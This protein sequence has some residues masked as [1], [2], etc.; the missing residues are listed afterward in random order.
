MATAE[1]SPARSQGIAREPL[2]H[3]SRRFD[4][5]I[6]DAGWKSPVAASL[7]ENLNTCLR[8]QTSS[9]I[10]IL[11]QEQCFE[12]F[13]NF[14][15]SIGNEPSIIIIDRDAYA[16]RRQQGFGFKLN[17]GLVRDEAT[18]NNLMKWVMAVLAEQTP[19]SDITEPIRT[20]IHKEGMRGAIDIL[21]D[22]AR[23]PMGEAL[24]H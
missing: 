3:G 8:Y 21:A 15:A 24:T 4:V 23:S 10:Y 11:K 20:V 14:P 22:V 9:N 17:L 7:R 6:L 16:V 2:P 1:T 18:A 5:F 13:K 12:F 19:G